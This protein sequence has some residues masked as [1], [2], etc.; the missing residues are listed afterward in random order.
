MVF[1]W[2]AVGAVVVNGVRLGCREA[3]D[4]SGRPVVLL[5]GCGSSSRTWDRLAA[6]LSEHRVIAVDLRGHATSARPGHY[7]LS[8]LRDDLLGL[9][10]TLDLRDTVLIGHSVGAY[11]A[12][13]AARLAPERVSR[14]V[15]EDLAAPPRTAQPSVKG[16]NPW[17]VLTAA[18]GIL[19]VRQD[20]DLRALA[21]LLRQLA[22]PDAGWW[23]RLGQVGHPTLILSGGPTSCIPPR[24]LAEA[25]LAL[26]DARL[27]TIPVGHRVHSLAPDRFATEVLSFLAQAPV[28]AVS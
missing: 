24:R 25:A 22:R 13:D 14:L 8:S 26:P 12:L 1:A 2:S 28:G 11:A 16:I 20:Y 5:H 18:L 9:L 10:E 7:P 21:S 23:A 17:Q 15:L 27:T 4:P 3:G 19:T 6:R